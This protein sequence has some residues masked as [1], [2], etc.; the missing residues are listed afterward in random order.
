MKCKC[1][2]LPAVF[3]IETFPHGLTDHLELVDQTNWLTLRQCSNCVQFWQLDKIDRLQVSLAIKLETD[4]NW[5]D[6]D[7]RPVRFNYLISS[8]GRIAAE[9]CIMEGR[10]EHA[11]NSLAHCVKH[12]FDY[13]GLRE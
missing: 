4:S 13:L 8:R 9:K 2:D 6:F 10:N 12:S 11:L 7:D 1:D 3:N 5:R